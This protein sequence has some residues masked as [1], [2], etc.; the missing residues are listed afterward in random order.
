VRAERRYQ[1]LVAKGSDVSLETVLG[2]TTLRDKQD[3]TRQDSP[4]TYDETY[5]VIDASEL[6]IPQVVDTIV[7]RV[8]SLS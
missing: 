4:L 5:T 7:A 6:T 2:E 8:K 3:S 1:E